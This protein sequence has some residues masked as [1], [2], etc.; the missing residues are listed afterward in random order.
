MQGSGRC[1]EEDF[2][3]AGSVGKIRKRWGRSGFENKRRLYL[4][5]RIRRCIDEVCYFCDDKT[6][7]HI[8]H[9]WSGI[10]PRTRQMFAD[11]Q[12]TQSGMSCF[13]ITPQLSTLNPGPEPSP[14]LA[15]S[16]FP[17]VPSFMGGSDES[18]I[19]GSSISQFPNVP[20]SMGGSDVSAISGS[21]IS[22]FPNV[23]SSMGGSDVSAISGSS[24]FSD[25]VLPSHRLICHRPKR[26]V[27]RNKRCL[28][29]GCLC[30]FT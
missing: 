14:L 7:T 10:W 21:S 17:N 5:P 3:S 29:P 28:L 19:S 20:S 27:F 4:F 26:H 9:S 25:E 1:S 11:I 6:H 8:Q 18:A 23:P 16:Q 13:L 15:P 22:Q 2:S 30:Y 12:Q 24:L